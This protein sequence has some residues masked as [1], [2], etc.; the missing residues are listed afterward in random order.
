M[1]MLHEVL[2]LLFNVSCCQIDGVRRPVDKG[3]L[4]GADAYAMKGRVL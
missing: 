4:F 1:K 2:E 3:V